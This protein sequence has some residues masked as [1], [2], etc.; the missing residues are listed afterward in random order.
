[1]PP[2]PQPC[3]GGGQPPN[4]TYTRNVRGSGGVV[5]QV[6]AANCPVNHDGHY[7]L[8]V[9]NGIVGDHAQ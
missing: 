9:I 7:D 1:M 4:H 3:P 2:R 5:R 8:P 6:T